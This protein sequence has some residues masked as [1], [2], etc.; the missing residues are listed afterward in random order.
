MYPLECM[1]EVRRCTPYKWASLLLL[2]ILTV[3]KV[4]S[5]HYEAFRS[6]GSG[7]V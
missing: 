4:E 3:L 5:D 6:Q 2:S 1:L 7:F